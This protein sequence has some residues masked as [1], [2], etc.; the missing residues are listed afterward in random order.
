MEAP[1]PRITKEH[2][3]VAPAFRSITSRSSCAGGDPC[4]SSNQRFCSAL[5]HEMGFLGRN[6]RRSG[7]SAGLRFRQVTGLTVG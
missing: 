6:S 5:I 3:A 4:M 7:P 1:R 2:E